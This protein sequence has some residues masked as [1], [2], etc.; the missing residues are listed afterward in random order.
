MVK[1]KPTVFKF[2]YFA[3]IFVFLI[4]ISGCKLGTGS[5]AVYDPNDSGSPAFLPAS[6]TAFVNSVTVNIISSSQGA[7]IRYTTDGTDPKTSGSF[8]LGGIGTSTASVW[9]AAT[10]TIKAYAY[11][12]GYESNISVGTFPQLKVATPVFSPVSGTHFNPN[13]TV[14]ITTSTQGSTIKYTDDGTDP[15]ISGSAVWGGIGTSDATVIL[16]A[17]KTIRAYAYLGGAIDSDEATST[18]TNP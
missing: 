3:S 4:V 10:T 6:G 14:T 9:I 13:L 11:K 2:I 15:K 8:F 16:N 7:T 17:T 1:M 5:P 12:A 18:Y